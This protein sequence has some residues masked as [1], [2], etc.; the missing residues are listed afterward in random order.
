MTSIAILL[1][2]AFAIITNTLVVKALPLC[3]FSGYCNTTS[4]CVKGNKCIAEIFSFPQCLA[5]PSTY[6]T[7]VGCIKNFG[8][9]CKDTSDCCDPG[10]YCDTTTDV[11][12]LHPQCK[13]PIAA[14]GL[15]F[16]SNGPTSS[17]GLSTT[18]SS[19][20]QPA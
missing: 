19:D 5:D 20:S 10:A 7:N 11:D 4:D 8:A 6:S 15:C 16:N 12:L 17:S 18:S 3:Q 14:T 13:Q 2:S 1:F 9:P